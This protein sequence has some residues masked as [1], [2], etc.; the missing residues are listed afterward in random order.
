MLISVP[1]TSANLG[2]GFDTLGL[3]VDL[4]NEIVIK[5][6]KF[7]SLSTHGEGADN[8]KIK[9]N[10]LFLS[11]FNEN[12]KRLSGKANNFRFEFTNRIP[13]SR[14]LGSSSAVIVAAL[15]GAY[16]M[17]GVKYNKREILNQALRYEHHPDNI[18]PAVM[19]GFNVACVEGDRVY[20]KKRRMPDYLRAVVVVPNRTISTA[21]SRTV[22]PKMYRKEETVYSLSRAAYMTALFMSESWDL[23]RIASKDKLHQARRMK[24]MPELFDVQKLA[25]KQGALMSTLSGSG[26]TFF[27]LAYEKDTDRIAQSLRA[28]FPQFRVFVLAL[29][30]NGVITK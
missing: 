6:S 9:K 22:L 10:S 4:R 25:L 19:G 29:D 13:I 14:G 2:P 27:N 11:I 8:P 1:A 30:N 28:R 17:A 26:S 24:M 23:L 18:T 15:S 20:S 7:L 5:P 16:A 3:A 12:Y 21:R